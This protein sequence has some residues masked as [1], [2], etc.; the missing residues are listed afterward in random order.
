M[1]ARNIEHRLLQALADTPVVFLGGARQTGKTTLVKAL[2]AST[3]AARFLTLDETATLAAAR[4]DPVGFVA[5]LERPVI[6]DEIQRVPEL[7]LPIKVRVDEERKP[8]GFL[9][10]GSAHALV[11][12]RLAEALAGRMEILTLHPFSQGEL[13]GV[14]EDL[15]EALFG[16]RLPAGTAGTLD[17]SA[18]AALLHQGGFPEAV[19]RT[20]PERRGA[21]FDSYV[22]SILQRDVAEL[23]QIQ[24][25]SALP[26]L[27]RLLAS[28][29]GTLINHA[30]LSRASGLP[31]TTLKR[32]L[33][34]LEATCLI[35][36]VPPW[37]ANLGRRLAR[38][39]K[40]FFSDAGLLLHL[41]GG[42]LRTGLGSLPGPVLENFV[43]MELLKQLTWSM[44]KAALF[45][46]RT[47]AGQEVDLVLE[48]R[49]GRLVGIEV[50]AASTVDAGDF[51]GLKALAEIAGDRF[52]RGILLHPGRERLPFGPKLHA[53]PLAE[54]WAHPSPG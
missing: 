20:R 36:V 8:G 46:F 33:A 34:L 40:L 39:P 29:A 51:K 28:R 48:D 37:H 16:D 26:A 5:D 47:H 45:H 3:H 15:I 22:A 27:L 42:S 53:L 1:R 44:R 50:K 6:L 4:A 12:P 31:Q 21:W 17:R 41:L 52:H 32:Y 54:L 7:F 18:L 25:L 10:T 13:A 14:L 19:A 24:G 35:Q 30:D 2:S 23:S 38:T 9:L 43:A 11:L 49:R